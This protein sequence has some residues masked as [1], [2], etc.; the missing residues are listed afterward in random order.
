MAG[1]HTRATAFLK[2]KLA[3]A[4]PVTAIVQGRIYEVFRDPQTRTQ[5]LPYIVIRPITPRDTNA[6]NSTHHRILTQG[7]WDVQAVGLAG[8]PQMETLNDALDAAIQA[9]SGTAGTD[10]YVYGVVREM[11]IDYPER[12]GDLLLRHL[13]GQY[14]VTVN[15][16]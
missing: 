4:S 13:G 16:P 15:I 14:R 11:A 2:A 7:I 10:G 12:V 5:R 8:T 1:E 3:A 9:T 6:L